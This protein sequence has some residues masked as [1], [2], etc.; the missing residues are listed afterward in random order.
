MSLRLLNAEAKGSGSV[1]GQV[2]YGAA[3]RIDISAR[4]TNPTTRWVPLPSSS[5]LS[6]TL[7]RL[8]TSRFSGSIPRV[9][10]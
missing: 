5:F 3:Y 9:F 8:P 1:T 2:V 4:Q 6:S 10:D 7:A